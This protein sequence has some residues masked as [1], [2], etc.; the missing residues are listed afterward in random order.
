MRPRATFITLLI[1]LSALAAAASLLSLATVYEV[2]GGWKAGE[3]ALLKCRPRYDFI[4]TEAFAAE[5]A[6]KAPAAAGDPATT[7]LAAGHVTIIIH[8]V[9]D[10]G[11]DWSLRLKKALLAVAPEGKR[12]EVYLFRWTRPDGGL[13]LLAHAR[14][15]LRAIEEKDPDHPEFEA[16][17][18]V[19]EARRLKEFL[20]GVRA[21]YKK[22]GVDGRVN[23]VA[24]SQGSLIAL[25]A[26]DLGADVDNL[27]VLGSPL[28][29]TGERQ[30]DVVAALPRVRGVL[31][32][33]YTPS[34]V[35]IR[36]MGGGLLCEPCGWPTKDLPGDKVVQT[37]LDVPGHTGYC[38]AEAIR[39][40]YVDKLGIGPGADHQLPAEKAAEFAG[41]WGELVRAARL[42]DPE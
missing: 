13:P 18:Q 5:A 6:G 33:Y 15:S 12:Q 4:A 31:Y 1:H 25:K 38:T 8:G 24:H 20:A 11:K 21:L 10:D 22:Y 30:D 16:A 23:I 26:L 32:N 37:K 36:F 17:Y 2:L 3:K 29:Y 19:E 9:N 34:D 14:N 28:T 39:A 7:R 41:R 42:I 27:V 40:N 35:A